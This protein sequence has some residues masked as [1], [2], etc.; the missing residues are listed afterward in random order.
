VNVDQ[1]SR[2]SASEPRDPGSGSSFGRIVGF[3]GRHPSQVVQFVLFSLLAIVIL[4][5]VE[6]TSIDVLFWSIA[7]VPKLLLIFLS[8]LVGAASW[9]LLRG[10]LRR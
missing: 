1:E 10:R 6:P 8:M 3:V 9:E 5:N 4:Q 7:S 2:S